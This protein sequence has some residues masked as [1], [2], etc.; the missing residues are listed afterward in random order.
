[1]T[2]LRKA[3]SCA[4]LAAAA[5]LVAVAPAL[6]NNV[7]AR[8]AVRDSAYGETLYAFYQKQYFP[9]IS[10]LL[11]ARE[12]KEF[13][14]QAGEAELLLGGLYVQ[15][16]M[17]EAARDV[18]ERL[19][20]ADA[21]QAARVWLALAE[22]NYRRERFEDAL[23]IVATR[24]E[25]A[26][27]PEE[28]V[29]IAVKSLMRMGRY[30]EAIEWL[31]KGDLSQRPEARYLR[32]NIAVA[33]VAA[34]NSEGGAVLLETLLKMPA[35]DDEMRALRDRVALALGATYLQQQDNAKAVATLQNARLNG[36]YSG[37][38]LLVY[39]IANLR[40][41]NHKQAA[42]AL[43]NLTK[44]SMHEQAVQEGWIA[45]GQVHEAR[46]D[47]RRAVATYKAA[48]KQL[49]G[50]LDY[51]KGQAAA[52]DNGQWFAAL[53]KRAGLIVLRDDRAGVSDD[54]VIGMPLHYRQF[55]GNRFVLTFAQYVEVSSLAHL[56]QG[57]QERVPVLGY[58][59]AS[60][61]ER[62]RRLVVEAGALLAGTPV[63][64]LRTRHAALTGRVEAGIAAD[65]PALVASEKRR[66]LL[67]MIAQ[68]E[69][70]MARWP[71]RDWGR[72]Q[73]KLALLRGVLQWE[74]AREQPQQA[75]ALRKVVRENG[76]LV[77]RAA[78]QRERVATAMQ[79]Q[80]ASVE[81]WLPSLNADGEKLSELAQR[82]QALR[83]KLRLRME[84]DARETIRANR[85]R[86]VGLAAEAYYALAQIEH[87]RW[88]ELRESRRVQP[89]ASNA[90]DAGNVAAQRGAASDGAADAAGKGN[91]GAA[92]GDADG[93]GVAGSRSSE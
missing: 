41:G 8:P 89:A 82:S 60:R 57:W 58:L 26:S 90:G 37:E 68:V 55:A 16:G 91:P 5:L 69:A 73:E 48:L 86:I 49:N 10:R 64:P 21:A 6:A 63:E 3:I 59:V 92:A 76:R 84:D 25:R 93:K 77:E 15:Y 30:A 72:Q 36:P 40:N 65:E 79:V 83:A 23:A 13:A 54:D 66:R 18:F 20:P 22:L 17:P 42:A 27:A 28:A 32:F 12:R 74:I 14:Q 35:A 61:E 45:L 29:L 24:F 11:V 38:L 9:A 81:G 7:P 87:G 67:A 75:W 39:G 2:R 62:H 78:A 56:V 53:E 88:K 50:E 44:R 70:R 85:E 46:D 71:E 51:L 80:Q 19:A 52:V 47:R 34:G 33:Q 4:G 1:V 43:G 31:G